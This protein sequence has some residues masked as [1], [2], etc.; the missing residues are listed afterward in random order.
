MVTE[1][2][3]DVLM[4]NA[5]SRGIVLQGYCVSGDAKGEE[6]TRAKQQTG[7]NRQP[8]PTL[9]RWWGHCREKERGRIQPAR[10]AEEET[11]GKAEVRKRTVTRGATRWKG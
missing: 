9:G 3:T 4:Y 8:T 2:K 1:K 10:G 6:K 5:H 11:E 7:T